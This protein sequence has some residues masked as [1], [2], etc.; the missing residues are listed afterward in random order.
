MAAINAHPKEQDAMAYVMDIAGVFCRSFKTGFVNGKG[1]GSIK[2][3]PGCS[4]DDGCGACETPLP[5]FNHTIRS[6]LFA[7]DNG[8]VVAY[9]AC[10]GEAS[11]VGKAGSMREGRYMGRL[12]LGIRKKRA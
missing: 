3:R 11:V 12:G 4:I 7:R 9:S 10:S 5:A 8:Y 2:I 6:V 1:L